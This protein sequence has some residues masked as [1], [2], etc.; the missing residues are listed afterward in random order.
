MSER[1][2]SAP[3]RPASGNRSHRICFMD[4]P[5]EGDCP[6]VAATI[7]NDPSSKFPSSQAEHGGRAAEDDGARLARSGGETAAAERRSTRR[8]HDEALLQ[9]HPS[10]RSSRLRAVGRPELA[11]HPSGRTRRRAPTTSRP[12]RPSCVGR[13]IGS[14]LQRQGT[15]M[16]RITTASPL[17]TGAGAAPAD[18]CPRSFV[19]M[20]G[21]C[22]TDVDSSARSF[23]PW[24]RV[25]S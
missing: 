21:L 23:W 12:M 17:A 2:K 3:V 7:D 4:L 25:G 8:C 19:S 1:A 16:A 14:A 9:A 11:R 5:N 20:G 15:A 6:V 22:R 18:L 24:W 10:P 13:G